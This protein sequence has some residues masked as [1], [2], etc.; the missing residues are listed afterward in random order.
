MEGYGSPEFALIWKKWDMELG[1]RICALRASGHRI[2][3]RGYGGWP[4]PDSSVMQ[5]GEGLESWLL[6]RERLKEEKKNGNSCG[7][8]LTMA[9]AM[10]GVAG[11]S[12]P[13]ANKRGFPD[14]HGS[15]EAPLMAPVA[16]WPTAQATD[17]DTRH[18]NAKQPSMLK[19]VLSGWAS[20]NSIGD[21]TGGGSFKSAMR[22]SQGLKRPS[23]ASYAAK[24]R[25]QVMISGQ[26]QMEVTT[27]YQALRSALG[28]TPTSSP[29]STASSGA[30]APAFSLW[31]MGFPIEWESCGE[32]A[33]RSSR[34][35][36]RNG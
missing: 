5:D 15:H 11:W 30:L 6:R 3:D 8:P 10:A 2:L 28:P 33:T 9:A 13:R 35:L 23:G 31:L 26:T 12:S 29:A 27:P 24:L 4:T 25:D 36:Q 1:Q 7:V 14:S 16:G 19:N 17:G 34:R 20:P 18:Q 21:T 32:Q 22:K